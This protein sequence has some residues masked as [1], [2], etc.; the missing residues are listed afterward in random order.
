MILVFVE[1]DGSGVTEASL[2]TVTFARDLAIRES[3]D[4]GGGPVHAVVVGWARCR[5]APSRRSVPT[6]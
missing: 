4:R 5:T 3:G 6:A 2:E 1:T